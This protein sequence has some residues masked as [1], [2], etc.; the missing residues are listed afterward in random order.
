MNNNYNNNNYNDNNAFHYEYMD[1]VQKTDAQPATSQGSPQKS[2][3]LPQPNFVANLKG[4][5]GPYY[6]LRGFP[7]KT[8]LAY[9]RY[10]GDGV[11]DAI[12]DTGEFRW[13]S[14]IDPRS[15]MTCNPVTCPNSHDDKFINDLCLNC[16]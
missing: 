15:Y 10:A 5:G 3:S 7:L 11:Y 9:S 14:D 4:Y 8:T 6:D 2:S 12:S 13:E 1:D 16:H